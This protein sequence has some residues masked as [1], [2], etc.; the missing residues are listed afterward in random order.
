MFVF[1]G[2]SIQAIHL[3]LI[4]VVCMMC[5]GLTIHSPVHTQNSLLHFQYFG[6][7]TLTPAS[8]MQLIILSFFVQLLKKQEIMQNMVAVFKLKMCSLLEGD[9][10]ASQGFC[11]VMPVPSPVPLA[12]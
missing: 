6:F 1:S 4:F 10:N 12:H 7:S 9:C 3:P 2:T 8:P 5:K 11:A